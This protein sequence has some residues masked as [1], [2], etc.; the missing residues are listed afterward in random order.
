MCVFSQ[1]Q[2]IH[3]LLYNKQQNEFSAASFCFFFTV[4]DQELAI[5]DCIKDLYFRVFNLLKPSGN[6]TYDQ[7]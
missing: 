3:K 5:C 1:W 7:V 4:Q 2:V 6:F